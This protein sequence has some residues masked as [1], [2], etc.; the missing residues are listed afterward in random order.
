METAA[1]TIAELG[2]EK[3]EQVTDA[4]ERLAAAEAEA[5]RRSDE[6]Q[7]LEAEKSDADHELEKQRA[8]IESLQ[9][10]SDGRVRA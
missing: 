3:V 7:R 6:L 5:R 8:R 1:T 4:E 10:E 9:H 2:A